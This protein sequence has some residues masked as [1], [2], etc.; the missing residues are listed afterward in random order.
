MEQW[1]DAVLMSALVQ[2][3]QRGCVAG[4]PSDSEGLQP[5]A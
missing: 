5:A 2:H 3:L 1:A 4:A